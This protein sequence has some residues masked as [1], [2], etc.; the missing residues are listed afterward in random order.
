[1]GLSCSRCGSL[2]GSTTAVQGLCPACLLR[3]A[4]TPPPDDPHDPESF[5]ADRPIARAYRIVTL[6]GEGTHGMTFLAQETSVRGDHVALT[7]LHPRTDDSS[8][9]ARFH[10]AR[11]A[12]S[13]LQHP[14]ISRVLDVGRNDDGRVYVATEFVPGTPFSSVTAEPLTREERVAIGWQLCDAVQAAHAA[15]VLH[16]AL[17]AAKVRM[18]KSEGRR[19]AKIL[20]FGLAAVIDDTRGAASDDV[21]ALTVLLRALQLTV[22]G[23][24]PGSLKEVQL[25]LV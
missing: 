18:T 20:D 22:P 14:H 7:V 13:S 15:H 1:V 23:G 24:I 8:I 12:L 3:M 21:A 9:L 11:P 19:I 17:S 6:L 25:R 4:V 5:D 16:L 10:Q 2:L